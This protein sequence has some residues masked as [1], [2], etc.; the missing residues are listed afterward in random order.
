VHA[1][2]VPRVTDEYRLEVVCGDSGAEKR[3]NNIHE[4]VTSKQLELRF[5]E[6]LW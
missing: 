4:D 2:D 3:R 6:P 1:K 5:T